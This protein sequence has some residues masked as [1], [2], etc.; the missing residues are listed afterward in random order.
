MARRTG[1]PSVLRWL[2]YALGFRLPPENREWVKHDLIDAGWRIRM[3]VRQCVILTPIAAVFLA[4]PG[5]WGLRGLIAGLVFGL[6][7]ALVA[8]YG[9]SL[10]AARLR[11][12]QLPV[13]EDP[14]LGGPTDAW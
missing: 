4:L 9:D 5:S 12:H 1:D 11:Q 8:M 6:G 14:D 10:R 7:L 13:P 3:L 2:G